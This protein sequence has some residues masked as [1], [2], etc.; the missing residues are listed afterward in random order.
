[1]PVSFRTEPHLSSQV[2]QIPDGIDENPSCRPLLF[3]ESRE[4]FDI[5][6]VKAK[7]RFVINEELRPPPKREFPIAKDLFEIAPLT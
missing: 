1:M 5:P 4:S 3:G 2:G 7:W 6:N